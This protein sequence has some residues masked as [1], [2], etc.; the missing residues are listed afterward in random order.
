MSTGRTVAGTSGTA[1]LLQCAPVREVEHAAV[2][3][4]RLA[5][6]PPHQPPRPTPLN[7]VDAAVDLVRRRRAR[8][9][10]RTWPTL[11][12][13]EVVERRRLDS[14]R[15]PAAASRSAPSRSTGC[16]PPASRRVVRDGLVAV[17]RPEVADGHAEA[18]PEFLLD[19]RR[20]LL[21]VR[22]DVPAFGHV[23]RV[24][25]VDDGRAERA[26]QVRPALAV[27]ERVGRSQSGIVV[28]VR[29]PSDAVVPVGG[30]RRARWP[31]CSVS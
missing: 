12:R 18:G 14:R 22:P 16:S 20:D 21:V 17:P 8:P 29:D 10:C 25:R 15:R 11:A 7:T 28:A 9:G 27:V 24:T 6:A 23:R 30:A 13:V 31:G 4:A 2:D 3:A 26:V 19:D 1:Q 5:E